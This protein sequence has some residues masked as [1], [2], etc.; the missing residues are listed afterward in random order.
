MAVLF[1]LYSTDESATE[2]VLKCEEA[3][4]SLCGKLEMSTPRDAFITAICKASLPPHY[5]LTVLNTQGGLPQ[6][7]AWNFVEAYYIVLTVHGSVC[8]KSCVFNSLKPNYS[9][10][11]P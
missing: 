8:P 5:A 10:D 2:S 4:I 9:I 3:Y 7:G 11:L 6:K 1:T